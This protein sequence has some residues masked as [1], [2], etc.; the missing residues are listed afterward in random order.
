MRAL[1]KRILVS[2]TGSTE[3][4]WE[5]KLREIESH[6]IK[7][8]ALFLEMF[9]ES[10]R[11]KIY[12]A[13]LSSHIEKIS[14]VHIGDDME[15]WELEFLEKKFKTKC[16]TIHESSFRHVGQ[17]QGFYKKLYLEMNYDNRVPHNVDVNRIAGFCIDLSHFKVSEESWN[18]EFEYILKREKIHRYFRCNHLNGY[19]YDRN[20]DVHRITN[21]N[22]F[23]YL[24]NLPNF[25]FGKYIA[26]EVF[27]PIGQQIMFKNY[28][29]KMLCKK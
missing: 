27:N 15:R 9:K 20:K 29:I 11:K 10:Q 28:L 19:D 1:K 23:N 17:W 5:S 16:F 3:R 26:L 25:L 21:L 14:Q 18:R 13:L 22:Q 7:R 2:I 24:K 12:L 4:D 8:I 6:K